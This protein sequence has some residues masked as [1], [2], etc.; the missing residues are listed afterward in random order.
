MAKLKVMAAMSGG[1][2]S[3][4]AAALLK[5]QGHQVTGVTLKL[6]QACGKES[7]KSCCGYA[8]ASDARRVCEK[9]GIPHLVLDARKLFASAVIDDFCSEYASGRTPNP[10]VRCNAVLKFDYLLKQAQFLGMGVVATGHY[11]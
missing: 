7:L 8:P 9:I 5:A 4:L 10:C 6:F 11:A 1:V 2:D 3:S